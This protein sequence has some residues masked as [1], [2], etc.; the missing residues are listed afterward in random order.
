M[1]NVDRTLQTSR[2]Q[3]GILPKRDFAVGSLLHFV[4]NNKHNIIIFVLL[5]QSAPA[6]RN[7]LS[8]FGEDAL[9]RHWRRKDAQIFRCR[10]ILRSPRGD[11]IGNT[12]VLMRPNRPLKRRSKTDRNV[13]GVWSDRIH[14]PLRSG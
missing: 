13:G 6:F 9:A 2:Q 5:L 14:G 4:A 11:C 10:P 1:L 8:D 7:Y 12:V 3:L